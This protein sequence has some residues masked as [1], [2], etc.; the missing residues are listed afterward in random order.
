L[1]DPILHRCRFCSQFR[2]KHEFIHDIITGY[3]WHCYEWH[4]QA[5]RVL[6]G[7]DPPGCQECGTPYELLRAGAAGDLRMY[8][9]PK[10]G[11]YQVLCK[12]C[13]DRYERKRLDLY[14]DTPYGY[15]QKL[16]G[17]N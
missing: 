5:L 4:Q 11:I 9:H 17:A 14:G 1:T 16:K 8:I 7:E 6:A 2:S 13:S 10:D 15:L 12:R 3:C